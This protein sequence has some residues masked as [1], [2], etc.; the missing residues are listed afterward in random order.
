M[1]HMQHID[2][3][4]FDSKEYSPRCSAPEKQLPNF[5]VERYALRG[6]RMG[7]GQGL[8]AQDLVAYAGQPLCAQAGFSDF[9]QSCAFRMLS[10]AKGV[11][12]TR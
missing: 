3:R 4:T 2:R 6:D 9:S 5:A 12:T 10:S 8:K 11:M 1:P 7:F